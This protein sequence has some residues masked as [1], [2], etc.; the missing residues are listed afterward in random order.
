MPA[1][2]I[3]ATDSIFVCHCWWPEEIAARSCRGLAQEIK[4]RRV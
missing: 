1:I 2:N 3:L 4:Q